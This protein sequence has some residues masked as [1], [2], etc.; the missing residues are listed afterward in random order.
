MFVW[1]EMAHRGVAK[2]PFKIAPIVQKNYQGIYEFVQKEL[3]RPPVSDVYAVS[4]FNDVDPE[5]SFVDV[6]LVQ[7]YPDDIHITDVEFADNRH[8]VGTH[9]PE[10]GLRN[11]RGLH[12]FGDFIARLSDVARSR[13]ISRISLMVGAKGLYPVFKRHGFEVSDTKMAQMAFKQVGLGFPMVRKV[14]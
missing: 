8:R 9:Q 1:D 7:C 11:Y 6:T 12:I 10:K 3:K 5:M 4:Y 14:K 13:N 2:Q